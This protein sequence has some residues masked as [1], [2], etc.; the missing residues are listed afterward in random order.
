MLIAKNTMPEP[1][2]KPSDGDRV[3]Q[4]WR[5]VGVIRALDIEFARFIDR[6]GGGFTS[7]LQWIACALVSARTAQGHVCLD[8]NGLQNADTLTLSAVSDDTL[9]SSIKQHYQAHLAC[10]PREQ[11]QQALQSCAAIGTPTD[12][13]TP[14]VL[15]GSDGQ[16]LLYLRRYWRYERIIRDALLARTRPLP[17]APL[18]RELLDNLFHGSGLA[19]EVD[20]QKVACALCAR[21]GFSIITGGPGTGKT[22]TVLRLL[23]LLQGLQIAQ[24]LPPWTIK[25][26]APTGKAAAR[27]NESIVGDLQRLNLNAPQLNEAQRSA[28]REAIPSEVST[29]HRLLGSRPGSRH[30]VHNSLNTLPADIVV[31]DEASMV[32]VEMMAKLCQAMRSSAR[33][34]LLGDKNQL[35][36]VEAG[37]VLGDLCAGASHAGYTDDT[38]DYVAQVSGEVVPA[39]YASANNEAT[40]PNTINQ[41]TTMLRH[42]YR[43]EGQ[44]IL[45][46][47]DWVNTQA[48]HTQGISPLRDMFHQHPDLTYV[49]LPDDASVAIQRRDFYRRVVEGYRPYLTKLRELEDCTP[50]TIDSWV[51]SLFKLHKTF[52][53]LAP[54][55]HTAYG[56]TALN[57][58]IERELASEG[59]LSASRQPWYRGR[60]VLVTQ[61]DYSLNLMNGDIGICLRLPGESRDRVA[62][63]Q[64]ED[65]Q[66]NPRIRWVL[67][68]RLQHVDTVFAMTVHKSQGSEFAHTM[69]VMPNQTNPVLSKELIYTAITRSK[70]HFTLVVPDESALEH[71]LSSNISRQSGL[72]NP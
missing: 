63:Y 52:Q 34:I 45:A 59:L 17:I 14:L 55:R 28:W 72:L 22:T 1:I 30:F 44:G 31:V 64:G 47:A 62:F 13:A 67:P 70:T 53:V 9:A 18:T 35:A 25:L 56:V 49:A 36:S 2:K 42:C 57:Q 51:A 7:A 32:D 40:L 5:S 11:W 38:L 33:L 10:Y 8:I 50:D 20:W 58:A 61:N 37:S 66:G 29:L 6:H 65:S 3:L 41:S 68:K 26:A 23:A 46:L 71:A 4:Y 19:L 16:Y 39:T 48:V 27:L 21:S 43:A 60:P 69:L 54:V 15:A 24:E 12:E